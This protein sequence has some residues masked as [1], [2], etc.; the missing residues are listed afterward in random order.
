MVKTVVGTAITVE[1]LV[2]SEAVVEVMLD[3]DAGACGD[4]RGRADGCGH[5]RA[6]G[7]LKVHDG[8]CDG[9]RD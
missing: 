7:G 2:L 1:A 6:Y 4:L 3:T 9:L 5:F 8:G